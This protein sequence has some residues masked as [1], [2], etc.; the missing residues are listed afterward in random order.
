MSFKNK[1]ALIFSLCILLCVG[2]YFIISMLFEKL[3]NQLFE[4]SRIE[5]LTG[6]KAM[7]EIMEFMIQADILT[8]DDILDTNYQKIS[9]TEP[10]KYRTRYDHV[11]DK[12]IQK[13]QDEY[14]RDPDVDYAILIDR[15]GYV[16]THNSRY[17]QI[18]ENDPQKNLLLNR[19]KR[20]FG[21][22]PAIKQALQ[23]HGNDT[24]TLLYDRDTGE[25]IW[26]VGAPV[27]IRGNNWGAFLI[28]ISM[29]RVNIIKNQ[30]LILII[31]TM[32]AIISLSLLAGLAVMP[33]KLFINPDEP[34]KKI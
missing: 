24:T 20:N 1:V 14:L 23:Y 32:F 26:N 5:A 8:L 11:F 7:S 33:R 34:P 15:N 25:R 17:S 27:R 21:N 10:Q 12:Y 16:P 28:G 29:Q 4:K 2:S 30:M 6:A 18:I 3:E 13:I 22:Y 9:G 31:V 19:T